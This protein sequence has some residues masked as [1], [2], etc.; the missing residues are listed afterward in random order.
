MIL[1]RRPFQSCAGDCSSTILRLR[2]GCARSLG[3][4]G[5]AASIA[6]A[7]FHATGKRIRDLPIRVEK[8][9]AV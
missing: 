7:V 6:N 9:I 5:V 2:G 1:Q 3:I 8:I 4:T